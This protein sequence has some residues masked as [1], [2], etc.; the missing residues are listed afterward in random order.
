MDPQMR[1]PAC[2]HEH[3]ILQSSITASVMATTYFST[4]LH[5]ASLS[6]HE[7]H[8]FIYRVKLKECTHTHTHTHTT[9]HTH[10]HTHTHTHTHISNGTAGG[11]EPVLSPGT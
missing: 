4:I 9:T 10:I 1:S 2:L 7:Q 6:I 5:G 3:C 11:R 8:M